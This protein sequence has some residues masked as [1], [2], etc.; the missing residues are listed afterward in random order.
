[1][2]LEWKVK[3]QGWTKDL[4]QMTMVMLNKEITDNASKFNRWTMQSI[5]AGVDKMRFAFVQRTDIDSAKSH[6]VVG[7]A[8]VN[9]TAF[10]GQINLN[11]TNCW[12]VLKDLVGA[13]L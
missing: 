10:A 8:N 3:R 13:V 5:I 4:D 12:A 2:L 7:M 1:M 6:K 11:V 9:P